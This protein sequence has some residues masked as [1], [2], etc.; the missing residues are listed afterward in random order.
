MGIPS[1]GNPYGVADGLIYSFPVTIENG[2]V[3]IVAGLDNNAF[4]REKMKASEAELLEERAAVE[5]ML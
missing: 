3:S 2:R 5:G 1:E 4:I